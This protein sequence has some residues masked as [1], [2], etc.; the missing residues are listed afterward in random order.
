MKARMISVGDIINRLK[1]LGE[2][3]SKNTHKRYRCE[4]LRCGRTSVIDGSNIVSGNTTGCN[5]CK[6]RK[7]TDQEE[8]EIV[9]KLGHR[10]FR[11]LASEYNVSPSTIYRIKQRA[12]ERKSWMKESNKGGCATCA[13]CAVD[14]M[15]DRQEFC[16]CTCDKSLMYMTSLSDV[17][18]GTYP[19]WG[20]T[21]QVEGRP[22]GIIEETGGDP[23]GIKRSEGSK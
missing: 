17:F 19:G 18:N 21:E 11:D 1:V 13:H 23:D 12:T 2:E 14:H 5:K 20:C 8:K 22:S 15:I 9:D 6:N 16:Q 7:F 3:E 10:S 4:C